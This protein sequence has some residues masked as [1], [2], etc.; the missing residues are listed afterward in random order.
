MLIYRSLLLKPS[1]FV[2]AHL[3][4]F[5]KENREFAI[6]TVSKAYY[7]LLFVKNYS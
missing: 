3:G 2:E 6:F 4:C 7:L 1:L 5:T